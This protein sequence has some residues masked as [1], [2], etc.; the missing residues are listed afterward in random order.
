[1]SESIQNNQQEENKTSSSKINSSVDS[2]SYRGS[3]TIKYISKKGKVKSISKHNTGTTELFTFI[4]RNLAG[5]D[6]SDYLPKQIQGYYKDGDIYKKSFSSPIGLRES[7][8][9]GSTGLNSI[10][11]PNSSLVGNAARY[12]FLITRLQVTNI[13]KPISVLILADSN[14]KNDPTTNNLTA[15]E[16]EACLGVCARIDLSIGE[17]IDPSLAYNI[18][19]YW[20]LS[21][22]NPE[23]TPVV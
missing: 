5:R 23:S 8:Q 12:T 4:V 22:S 6:A 15:A 9:V 3:V 18:L 20:V 1:M 7:V 19:V 16:L 21:F 2:I 17:E 14:F 11:T 10:F 13:Q